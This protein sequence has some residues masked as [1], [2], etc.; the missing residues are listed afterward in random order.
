MQIC[1]EGIFIFAKLYPEDIVENI[2]ED[3]ENSPF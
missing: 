1:I 3:V 2:V